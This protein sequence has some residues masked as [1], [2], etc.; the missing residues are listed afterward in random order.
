VLAADGGAI[1][2]EVFRIASPASWWLYGL[3]CR[4]WLGLVPQIGANG[5]P[6]IGN[7]NFAVLVSDARAS[8]A[9]AMFLAGSPLSLPLGNG[10]GLHVDLFGANVSLAFGTNARGD[11]SV[12]LGVP[13]NLGLLGVSLHAQM[14]LADA[15]GAYAGLAALTGGL[16]MLIAR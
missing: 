14:V 1:G 11:G 6:E 5:A 4:G 16:Q 2:T 12:A 9:G 3:G 7:A 15:G 10:C 8:T 13:F